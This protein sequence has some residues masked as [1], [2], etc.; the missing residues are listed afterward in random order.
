MEVTLLNLYTCL[1]AILLL[2][3]TRLKLYKLFRH[4]SLKLTTLFDKNL[5][6]TVILLHYSC[7]F[8]T[9]HRLF[10]I[11]RPNFSYFYI[12]YFYR[13]TSSCSVLR[14]IGRVQQNIGY[15]PQFDALYDELTARE[16]LQFYSRL[17]GIPVNEEAKVEL[18]SCNII[19]ARFSSDYT[20]EP[21]L[22]GLRHER[23][24][25]LND[26]F[27]RH[28]LFL[29]DVCTTCYERPPVLRDAFAAQKGWS[30]KTGSTV[31]F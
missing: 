10:L 17:R 11:P 4:I 14:D 15:C 27:H 18:L 30:L 6:A 7:H 24:L 2:F 8:I 21:V 22:G 25:V 3:V 19:I 26:R 28:G 29:I 12:S 13:D 1:T 16:H 5:Y 20:V 31:L 9:F 23:P